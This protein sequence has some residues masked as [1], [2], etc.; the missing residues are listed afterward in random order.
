[1]T[2]SAPGTFPAPARLETAA[3]RG[4]QLLRNVLV[5]TR[6]AQWS[7]NLL[8][9][10][11]FVFSAGAAWSWLDSAQWLPMLLQATAA[12]G[13]FSALA[14][15]GY[16]LNDAR[17][18]ELDRQHPRK[19]LRP[20]AAGR[21]SGRVAIAV[22]VPLAA[23]GLGGAAILGMP[24]LA[25][26]LGYLVL[27]LAY[28]LGLKRLVIVDLLAVASGFGLRAVGG[29]AAIHVPISPWIFIVTMLGALLLV[30]VKRRQEAALAPLG[31]ADGSRRTVLE[32]YT[33]AFLDQVISV[34]TSATVVAY[35]MYL[36]TA[37][38]LPRDHSMLVTLPIVLYG[39][40]RFRWIADRAPDRNVDELIFRD[41]PLLAAVALFGVA[42]LVVLAAHQ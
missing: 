8:V 20:I 30:T 36:T 16:L 21:L 27:T 24:F 39:L 22:A 17:D 29:A 25:T 32:G 5:S 3:P 19:R 26:A 28:S 38:N 11:A 23:T 6:P 18:A 33:P 41:G 15:A 10:A 35:A 37:P 14:S 9:Y 2:R 4:A 1:M 40:L 12:F 42:A 13:V 7:K 31:A 34:A